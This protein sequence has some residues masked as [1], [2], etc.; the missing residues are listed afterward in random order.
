MKILFLLFNYLNTF[1]YL[2]EMNHNAVI[3]LTL[4]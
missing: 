4:N 2:I 1:S 3:T